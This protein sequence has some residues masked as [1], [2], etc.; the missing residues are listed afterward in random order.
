MTNEDTFVSNDALKGS[1]WF[2]N[3]VV[4]NFDYLYAEPNKGSCLKFLGNDEEPGCCE[5]FDCAV[6][7]DDS[8]KSIWKCVN[9]CYKG[10][11]S[12]CVVICSQ[13]CW[14]PVLET[15][16]Q[17]CCMIFVNLVL[18]GMYSCALQENRNWNMCS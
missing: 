14:I 16:C 15:T 17:L 1:E 6:C 18:G 5:D 10:F 3:Q 4:E 11:K 9:G 13:L 8:V 7:C 2:S 12:I